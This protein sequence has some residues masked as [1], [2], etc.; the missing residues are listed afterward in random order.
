MK[1]LG[2]RKISLRVRDENVHSDD[3]SSSAF[4][5]LATKIADMYLLFAITPLKR[6]K[7]LRA[8]SIPTV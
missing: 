4:N 2:K 6:Q 7:M 3:L 1:E 5:N 8:Y